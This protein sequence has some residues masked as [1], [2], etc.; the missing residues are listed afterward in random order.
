MPLS[1]QEAYETL[2]CQEAMSLSH[3]QVC[4]DL[5]LLQEDEGR[6]PRLCHTSSS[7]GWKQGRMIWEGRG[8]K[9]SSV[10]PTHLLPDVQFLFPHLCFGSY[11]WYSLLCECH[12]V[13]THSRSGTKVNCL[14]LG[15]S[16]KLLAFLCSKVFSHLKQL[17]YI[18]LR[19]DPR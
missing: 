16:F 9:S 2:L 18:V 3:Y 1:I 11:P 17:G 4:W 7:H 12:T 19:F 8:G 5:Q 10:V 14:C 13:F 15:L 6:K